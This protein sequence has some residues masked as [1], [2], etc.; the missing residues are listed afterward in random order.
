MEA[1]DSSPEAPVRKVFISQVNPANA[2]AEGGQRVLR[3][4]PW[5][6]SQVWVQGVVVWVAD[7]QT[8]LKLDDGTGVLRVAVA[9]AHP[10]QQYRPGTYLLAIGPYC[11]ADDALDAVQCV[12]LPD[13][14]AQT[15]W[16]LEVMDAQ[17]TLLGSATPLAPV[18][19]EPGE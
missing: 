15:I 2:V 19:A 16:T 4:G 9:G 3:L 8:H 13:P 5:R 14:N 12:V 7:P 1:G 18:K 17:A 11:P 10:P 6:V